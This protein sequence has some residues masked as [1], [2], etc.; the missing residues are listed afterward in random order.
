MTETS[1]A[2]PPAEP[3]RLESCRFYQTID[4]PDLGTQRGQWDLRPGIDR[5]LGALDFSGRRVLE[6]G[7][8]NGFVCF[9]LERRGAEVVAF[10]LADGLVYDAQPLVQ[11]QAHLG[12][13]QSE[14][15]AGLKMIKN[16]YWLAHHQLGSRARVAYGHANSLPGFLGTFDVAVLANVLQHLQDPIGAVIQAARI[17]DA[18]VVTEADWMA[19]S[20]E[21]LPGM[22]LFDDKNPFTWYQV[23]PRLIEMV[24][25][26]IGFGDVTVEYHE[27]KL[28]QDLEY[29]A[30]SDPLSRAWDKEVPHFTVSARRIK[31]LS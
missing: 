26:R 25:S 3:P 29:S 30:E 27:Q 14:H 4:L 5:Y 19:G 23:K 2:Q 17:S 1:Y 8:A 18:I 7:T 12:A 28:L 24:L 16:A 20:Y 15:V 31:T 13:L 10:D 21:D 6:I 22:V 11:S 9:E